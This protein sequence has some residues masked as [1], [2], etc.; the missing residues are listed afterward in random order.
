LV[1][2]HN[3]IESAC[4][5]VTTGTVNTLNS[6]NS[7]D[8][9]FEISD[10]AQDFITNTNVM[11]ING[12]APGGLL[13][14]KRGILHCYVS[15]DIITSGGSSYVTLAIRVNGTNRGLHLITNTSGQWDGFTAIQAIKVNANDVVSFNMSASDITSVDRGTWGKYNFLFHAV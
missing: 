6:N 14:K 3:Y 1:H 9:Y 8:L 4:L 13:I 11:S 10:S 5:T 7:G 15:H 2:G 12:S